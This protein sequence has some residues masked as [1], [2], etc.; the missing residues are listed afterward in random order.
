MGLKSCDRSGRRL[1]V[2]FQAIFLF[3]NLVGY[4]SSSFTFLASYEPRS[5]VTDHVS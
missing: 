5:K 4:A 3:G 1:G 2:V